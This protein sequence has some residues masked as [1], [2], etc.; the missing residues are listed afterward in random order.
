MNKIKY[1]LFIII[2]VTLLSYCNNNNETE[3]TNICNSSKYNEVM[4]KI[5]IGMSRSE[6]EKILSPYNYSYYS[7]NQLFGNS[8]EQKANRD[9]FSGIIYVIIEEKKVGM[10]Q[11][12]SEM[13]KVGFNDTDIVSEKEC[14][15][16]YTGL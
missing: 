16:H 12:R 6:I 7:K 1:K 10:F 9:K 4:G 11:L 13:I 2:I 14:K 8:I 15:V 5:E 3:D